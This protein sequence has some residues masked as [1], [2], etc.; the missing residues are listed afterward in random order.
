MRLLIS[1]FFGIAMMK[2]ALGEQVKLNYDYGCSTIIDDTVFGK[3]TRVN[4][5]DL[6]L[7]KSGELYL[8]EKEMAR[9]LGGIYNEK[10]YKERIIKKK[11]KTEVVPFE[12]RSKK[13]ALYRT[14]YLK[15]LNKK[16]FEINYLF[17]FMNNKPK[18]YKIYGGVKIYVNE[19]EDEVYRKRGGNI[20]FTI[21]DG[22]LSIPAEVIKNGDFIPAEIEEIDINENDPLIASQKGK[23]I[24]KIIEINEEKEEVIKEVI[25]P[26]GKL[27]L[28]RSNIVEMNM[29][30][31]PKDDP[32]VRI[33][34]V[35]ESIVGERI[36]G[37]LAVN[38]SKTLILTYLSY[39]YHVN[40]ECGK[41]LALFDMSKDEMTVTTFGVSL[42]CDLFK[43]VKFIGEDEAIVTI[44]P[45]L[46]FHYKNR[47]MSLPVANKDYAAL[48]KYKWLL[49]AQE[50]YKEYKKIENKLKL[51]GIDEIN[52]SEMS[53]EELYKKYRPYYR[54]ESIPLF[55][56][57]REVQNTGKGVLMIEN[58][59]DRKYRSMISKIHYDDK[60]L[61]SGVYTPLD[62]SEL[63]QIIGKYYSGTLYEY[64]KE[65]DFW[66][67][68]NEKCGSEGY[69]ID[70]T[71]EEPK[72]YKFG[73]RNACNEVADIIEDKDRLEIQMRDGQK[74]Y[75]SKG[76]F[77][78]PKASKNY[79]LMFPEEINIEGKD[80]TGVALYKT[81]PP[82]AE[83]VE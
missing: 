36:P 34:L 61:Y 75:Y 11:E 49:T 80:K 29:F 13:I 31:Y 41:S 15:D 76:K 64:V 54:R 52:E 8:N 53:V 71:E 45:N 12:Y 72:M 74:Y 17:N 78:L 2:Q 37:V 77:T 63:S 73:N 40:D 38:E 59:H 5:F 25:T 56:G 7:K 39:T 27:E 83:L 35:D 33:P 62:A 20:I 81:F 32:A 47:E 26:L 16:V 3:I 48:L 14:N 51:E 21:K 67:K 18:F 28:T 82:Y 65:G 6:R 10:I 24:Y 30:L 44:L 68:H 50:N 60:V 69:L 23:E 42:G 19:K 66:N 70:V 1:L 55:I 43:S 9:S 4:C 58:H 57:N 46:E 22:K 79:S